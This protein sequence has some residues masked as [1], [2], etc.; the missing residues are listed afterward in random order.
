MTKRFEDM[1]LSEALLSAENKDATAAERCFT[2][3]RLHDEF[4]MK[5]K[6]DAAPVKLY[7]NRYG[8]LVKVFRIS[9]CV[10]LRVSS[11]S[12]HASPLQLRSRAIFSIK[13]KLRS[14]KMVAA[15]VAG[16]WL[17]DEPLFLDTETT[18]L[19]S[20]AQIIEIAVTDAAGRALLETRLRPTVPIDAGALSVHGIGEADL[21]CAPRW[22][23]IS[24]Q[25]QD[26]LRGRL[27]VIFNADF[28]S[29]MV[30]QTAL[31]FDE[32]VDWWGKID[33]RCA[34]YLA[35]D[36]FGPTNRYG[37]ISLAN[38]TSMAGVQW[39]GQSH[40]A[41]A[42]ARATAELVASIAK[43]RVALDQELGALLA[44]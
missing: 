40:T 13:A 25:L 30:R 16:D 32:S 4:H 43:L 20:D 14:P 10:P 1:P 37:T 28:D 23:D 39:V 12:K 29:R 22:P 24:G 31:A 8:G 18:G 41:A 44:T 17:K 2:K 27:V 33:T 7:K 42:D 9:D 34:M 26:L 3:G 11:G 5:P 21:I 35:A 6:A 15:G 36:T 38:A 19:N